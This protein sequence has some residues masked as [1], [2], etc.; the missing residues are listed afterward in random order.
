MHSGEAI[1]LVEGITEN[2][3]LLE[4]VFWSIVSPSPNAEFWQVLFSE[5][6]FALVGLLMDRISNI[7]RWMARYLLD[8]LRTDPGFHMINMVHN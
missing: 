2:L 8:T 3:G 4:I 5:I 6:V 7:W 1:W